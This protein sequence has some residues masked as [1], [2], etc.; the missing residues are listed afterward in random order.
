MAI[1]AGDVIDEARDLHPAF[2]KNRNPVKIVRRAL[3]RYVSDLIAKINEIDETAITL[4]QSTPM[5]LAVFANG[6]TLPANRGVQ[7]VGAV[8]LQGNVISVDLIPAGQRD[9]PHKMATAWIIN[10]VLYLNGLAA[11]WNSVASI[12]VR[13][14]PVAGQVLTDAD[15]LSL[16]DS[17]R[18]AVVGALAAFMAKR[19]Q[20][21]KD[22]DLP[23]IDVQQFLT[24]AAKAESEFLT[25]IGNTLTSQVFRVRDVWPRGSR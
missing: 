12:S 14:A 24:D 5:P 2:D 7:E 20:T 18:S 25:E 17:A 13:Y 19:G 15:L 10:G 1:L 22:G 3:S 16:P 6:I 8:D 4:E 21:D 11:N 9:Q 23:P